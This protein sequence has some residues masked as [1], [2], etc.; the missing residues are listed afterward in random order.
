MKRAQERQPRPPPERTFC[1]IG[2]LN[3]RIQDSMREI[4][5]PH[6]TRLLPCLPVINYEDVCDLL[7]QCG[8]HGCEEGIDRCVPVCAAHTPDID[9]ARAL[10]LPRRAVLKVVYDKNIASSLTSTPIEE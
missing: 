5:K 9:R 2:T 4:S 3:L 1:S 7:I 6:I 10:R 8:K